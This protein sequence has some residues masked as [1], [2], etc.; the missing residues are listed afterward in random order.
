M[1][2]IIDNYDSFTFNLVQYIGENDSN[3]VVYKNDE[4][5]VQDLIDI[6]PSKI[7]ISG[8]NKH[9]N[10]DEY[11]DEWSEINTGRKRYQYER[12]TLEAVLFFDFLPYI[13]FFASIRFIMK[14]L[15]VL[16]RSETKFGSYLKKNKPYIEFLS[17]Q[18]HI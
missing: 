3:V 15:A 2:V 8:N 9:G 6:N 16:M 13:E 7:I 14:F 5:S 10:A 12:I 17:A 4:V 18:N 11:R 1:N